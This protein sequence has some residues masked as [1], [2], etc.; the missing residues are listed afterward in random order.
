M[1]DE[2]R[3]DWV[4]LVP[5]VLHPSKVSIIEALDWI[6]R[7]MSATELTK[8][9]DQEKK[10]SQLSYHV[11]SLATLKVI[12][13]VKIKKVRGADEHFYFFRRSVLKK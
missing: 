3:L 11:N 12:E 4:A 5:H 6:N 9:L 10:L 1:G 7:P 8:V 2:L 13:K